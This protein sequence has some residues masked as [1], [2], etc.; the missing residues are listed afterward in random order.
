[1]ERR[2][3]AVG[4]RDDDDPRFPVFEPYTGKKS[5]I[6]C[7]GEIEGEFQMLHHCRPRIL[8]YTAF[9]YKVIFSSSRS[10]IKGGSIAV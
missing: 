6:S 7:D 9:G 8:D 4:A 5:K 10:V 2:R 3:F 1:M